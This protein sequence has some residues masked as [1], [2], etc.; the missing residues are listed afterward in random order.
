MQAFIVVSDAPYAATTDL[1]GMLTLPAR[2]A[3]IAFGFGIYVSMTDSKSSGKA[4]LPIQTNW[5]SD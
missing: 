3:S 1:E 4:P 5:T 2:L